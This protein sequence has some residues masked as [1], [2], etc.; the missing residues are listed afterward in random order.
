M[1][2]EPEPVL[3]AVER[4]R[5]KKK[6]T[7]TLFFSPS[8]RPFDGVY[9][10]RL[11]IDFRDII[12]IAGHYE[13]IDARVKKITRAEAVSIGPYVLTGGEL[14]AMIVIDA[15]ARQIPGVLGDEN[16]LEE[17]RFASAETYTRPE[18]LKYKNKKPGSFR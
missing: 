15:T 1:V 8:G 4:A 14:P 11:A 7:K 10:R 12:L 13:G 16:S 6:R 5:G 17:N 9:A 18:V 2:I 3:R